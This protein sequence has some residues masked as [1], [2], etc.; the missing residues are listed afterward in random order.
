MDNEN[1][2]RWGAPVNESQD[3]K[4]WKNPTPSPDT[5]TPPENNNIR[6]NFN[7]P[8][9][10]SNNS[11]E[12]S[13]FLGKVSNLNIESLNYLLLLNTQECI[14]ELPS[15]SKEVDNTK[16][17]YDINPPKE[18]SIGGIIEQIH[19]IL[20]KSNH[21][22]NNC[23]LYQNFKNKDE[24]KL[25]TN[26]TNKKFIFFIKKDIDSGNL[27]FDLSNI[28]GPQLPFYK[29]APGVLTIIPGWVPLSLN[30]SE[31]NFIVIVGDIT[32]F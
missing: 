18:S 25:E 14:Q 4:P 23:Y 17:K 3:L 30:S 15:I 27:I 10:S 21:K 19:N 11:L 29:G 20:I 32:S 12:H 7:K 28:G 8:H 13:F 1:Q 5:Q 2:L 26:S 22:I 16:Q 9:Q 6:F 31:G 24:I